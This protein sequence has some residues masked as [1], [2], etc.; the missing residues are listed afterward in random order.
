M[1]CVSNLDGIRADTIDSALMED[2]NKV[3]SYVKRIVSANLV[4]RV[5]DVDITGAY[6]ERSDMMLAENDFNWNP[7]RYYFTDECH[8]SSATIILRGTMNGVMLAYLPML[9]SV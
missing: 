7:S 5:D 1:I 4:S 2:Q 8:P 6:S 9:M 3:K